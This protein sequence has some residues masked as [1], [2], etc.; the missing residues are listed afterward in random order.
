MKAVWF[1]LGIVIM[2]LIMLLLPILL[3]GCASPEKEVWECC[4][5]TAGIPFCFRV[6]EQFAKHKN[7]Y[8]PAYL[9]NHDRPKDM[10]CRP[11]KVERY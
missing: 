5:D 2:G 7:D 9:E 8:S 4:E 1:L 3:M 6:D 11:R 10:P